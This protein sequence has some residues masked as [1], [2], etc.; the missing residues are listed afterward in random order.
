MSIITITISMIDS[1]S[2]AICV[3]SDTTTS[4]EVSARRTVSV[5]PGG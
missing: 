5:E 3:T 1:S 4:Y 2:I